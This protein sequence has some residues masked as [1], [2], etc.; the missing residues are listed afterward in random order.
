MNQRRAAVPLLVAALVATLG[1]TSYAV[2][3]HRHDARTAAP[4]AHH[5]A[6]DHV[7]AGT[8]TGTMA[9]TEGSPAT[10]RQQ[11]RP[12]TSARA[13]SVHSLLRGSYLSGSAR[14]SGT[15]KPVVKNKSLP[16][17]TGRSVVGGTLAAS[18]GRWSPMPVQLSYQWYSG[19][20]LLQG[21]TKPTYSPTVKALGAKITVE[22][23]AR[24]RG[25]R[26]DTALSSASGK[27]RAGTITNLK[28]PAVS[29]RSKTG[30]KLT[31]STGKWSVSGLDL[32]YQWYRSGKAVAGATKS[33][34]KL[35]TTDIG[36]K[37]YAVVTAA[38]DGYKQTSA[39]T[40]NTRPVV[41]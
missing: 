7:R 10:A 6:K 27:V 11:A 23:T 4:A 28:D 3:G 14:L 18:P 5:A 19:N 26:T 38:R 31:V 29:G 24:K 13:A 21:A 9:R 12:A 39:T 36:K 40:D 37:F 25:Y 1:G 8:V 15:T 35:K 34:L 16:E 30:Q 33:T 20:K 32:D 2:A 22:V 17:I 41:K